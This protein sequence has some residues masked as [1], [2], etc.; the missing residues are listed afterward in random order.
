[1]PQNTLFNF[2]DSHVVS[3]TPPIPLYANLALDRDREGHRYYRFELER[4][5]PVILKSETQEYR[6]LDHHVS[7]YE[8]EYRDNPNLSQYHYTAY[9]KN[10]EGTKFRLHVYFNA[11]DKLTMKAAFARKNADT[12]T[13]I[14]TEKLEDEFI[15]LAIANVKPVITNLRKKH[16]DIVKTLEKQYSQL[17]QE[18]RILFSQRDDKFDEYIE[19]LEEICTTLKALIPLVRHKTYK[20]IYKFIAHTKHSMEAQ[21]IAETSS[22]TVEADTKSE[23]MEAPSADEIA[24]SSNVHI[25]TA[26][27]RKKRRIPQHKNES[28]SK[29]ET[30]VL[31]LTASFKELATSDE[32]AQAKNIELLLTKIYGLSLLLEERTDAPFEAIQQL[33]NLRRDLHQLGEKLLPTLLLAKKEFVLAGQ[34][35]SFHHLLTDKYLNLALQM[36]NVE[37][38]DFVLTYGDFNLNSQPVTVRD[39][40]YQSAAHACVSCNS[41]SNPM[42]TCLSIL[43][44]HGASLCIAGDNGLPLAYEIMSVDNHPLS[45]ALIENRNKTIDSVTFFQELRS[46]LKN[47]LNH[48]S[49]SI[50]ER[51]IM[52][53]EIKYYNSRIE[54]LLAPKMN[55][56]NE[57]LLKKQMDYFEEKHLSSIADKLRKDPEICALNSQIQKA[58][59]QLT[60]LVPKAALRKATQNVRYTLES[61]D[62]MLIELDVK[63]DDFAEVK[64]AALNHLQGSLSLINKEIELLEVQKQLKS[65]PT[66]GRKPSSTQKSLAKREQTLLEEIKQLSKEYDVTQKVQPLQELLAIVKKL[67]PEFKALEKL[68]E[69]QDSMAKL[70]EQFSA[71]FTGSSEKSKDELNELTTPSHELVAEELND[72]TTPDDEFADRPNRNPDTNPM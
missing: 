31:Q 30:Q 60:K 69:Q 6:L 68:A 43:L 45:K 44:K 34:L 17:E 3:N 57:G 11:N 20:E 33:D 26:L 59:Q 56:Q 71:L 2:I 46:I 35:T 41:S 12:F 19:K 65:H 58:S 61:L 66:Y 42:S 25:L 28:S 16:T 38:L 32:I 37:L 62:K 53:R 14:N 64:A 48:T 36:R 8:T 55:V 7:I 52:T 15:G 51:S 63:L 5:N 50:E 18:A 27:S 1:M 9:F 21:M 13:A 70:L 24:N 39:K 40:T 47:Y 49:V 4:S 54:V 22:T 29:L 72:S 23:I 10:R 67:E